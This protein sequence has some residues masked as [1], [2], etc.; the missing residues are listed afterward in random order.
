ME[1]IRDRQPRAVRSNCFDGNWNNVKSPERYL[2]PYNLK[3]NMNTEPTFICEITSIDTIQE[4]MRLMHSSYKVNYR[5]LI[6]I[7]NKFEPIRIP[8]IDL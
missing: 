6:G 7:V 1:V 5:D 8:T 4:A 2:I 3:G